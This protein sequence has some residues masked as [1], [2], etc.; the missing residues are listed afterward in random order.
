MYRYLLNTGKP[1]LLSLNKKFLVLSMYGLEAFPLY[2]ILTQQKRNINKYNS[3]HEVS[4]KQLK[5]TE[6]PNSYTDSLILS[7]FNIG[8]CFHSHK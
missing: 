3:L 8:F 6:N 1:H 2:T 7:P 5:C 4:R